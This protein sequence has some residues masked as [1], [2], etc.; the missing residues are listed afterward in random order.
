MTPKQAELMEEL[1]F[2]F[3][4][5]HDDIELLISRYESLKKTFTLQ[6][7]MTNR[8]EAVERVKGQRLVIADVTKKINAAMDGF[9]AGLEG[10]A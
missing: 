3:Q 5:L 6:N 10:K 8:E 4:F 7:V 1:Q 9:F 2:Q